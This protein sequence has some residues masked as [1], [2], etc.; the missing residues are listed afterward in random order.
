MNIVA[1]KTLVDYYTK[2]P[3]A[4]DALEDWYARTRKSHWS[5]FADVKE[6]FN[7][8]D[9]VGNQHYVFNIK[10]NDFRL[11]VVI[12]FRHEYVYIRFVGTHAEY[13]KIK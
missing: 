10:G 6:S 8:V 9:S 1:K 7:S 3:G 2:H 12:Q 4:R 5:C 11:I 13:D